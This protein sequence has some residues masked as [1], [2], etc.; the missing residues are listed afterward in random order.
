[1]MAPMPWTV[2]TDA[3]A[4]KDNVGWWYPASDKKG[5][6]GRAYYDTEAGWVVVENFKY[7]RWDRLLQTLHLYDPSKG[8]VAEFVGGAIMPAFI[9]GAIVY[10]VAA[11]PWRSIGLAFATAAFVLFWGAAILLVL[12]WGF[13]KVARALGY[14]HRND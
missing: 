13:D 8:Q 1:M 7:T 2:D 12:G 10:S 11:E 9:G 4:V 14:T 5:R 6:P 3:E